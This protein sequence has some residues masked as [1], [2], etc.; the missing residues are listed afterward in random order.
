[1]LL[2]NLFR[3]IITCPY[4]NYLQDNDDNEPFGFERKTIDLCFEYYYHQH[5]MRIVEFDFYTEGKPSL[6]N[7]GSILIK[8]VSLKPFDKKHLDFIYE[9]FNAFQ[10]NNSEDFFCV[11][12]GTQILNLG[13]SQ[14]LLFNKKN[15]T[16]EFFNSGDTTI[17]D[18]LLNFIRVKLCGLFRLVVSDYAGLQGRDPSCFIWAMAYPWLRIT[19]PEKSLNDIYT[20]LSEAPIQ[21]RREILYNFMNDVRSFV[22]LKPGDETMFYPEQFVKKRRCC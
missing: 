1:M 16:C 2:R 10:K 22:P 18:I 6:Q 3:K 14:C 5:N 17:E 19:Q 15:S 20:E 12:I 11:V 13:H 4:N 7:D 9:Q 8:N 21:R